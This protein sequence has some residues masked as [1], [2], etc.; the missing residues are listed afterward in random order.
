MIVKLRTPNGLQVTQVCIID[1]NWS[2]S[3]RTG[4]IPRSIMAQRPFRYIKS[5]YLRTLRVLDRNFEWE[6]TGRWMFY[7][8]MIGAAGAFAA[9]A[10]SFL[11]NFVSSGALVE[12]IGYRG[13]H[14]AHARTAAD[15][16]MITGIPAS[17][18]G[19]RMT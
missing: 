8:V 1:R 2:L 17:A 19:E 15:E 16:R 3:V 13:C 14:V 6:I 11:V 9:L 5:N 10:F 12:L 18:K 4:H 7:S